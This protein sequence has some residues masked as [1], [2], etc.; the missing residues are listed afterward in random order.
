[1]FFTVRI[2]WCPNNRDN[3]SSIEHLTVATVVC[4][5]HSL[6]SEWTLHVCVL[7]IPISRQIYSPNVTL[8]DDL[9]ILLIRDRV[10]EQA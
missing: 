1:M 8:D 4:V 3:V 10:H 7:G 5:T 2:L 9:A 6:R